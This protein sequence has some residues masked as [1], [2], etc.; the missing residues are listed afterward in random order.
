VHPAD[1]FYTPVRALACRGVISGYSDGSFRPFTMTTRAQVVK[2]LVLGFGLPISVPPGG[3][4]TFADVPPGEVFFAYIET[5]AAHA[6]ISGYTCGGPNEP[7]DDRQR[8]YFRPYGNVTRGQLTKV[9]ALAAGW[10]LLDPPT[11][12][13]ADVAR[14]TPFYTM[15]ETAAAHGI[16]SGYTCGG[17]GEP[18]DPGQRPYFRQGNN[19]TRGQIAKIVYLAVGSGSL[20]H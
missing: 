1:Y 9:T 20:R 10:T 2:I 17:V 18:C 5:A 7:C 12:T 6:L 11:G 3:D 8:P 4:Y 14:G 13:F 15:V 16:I 19:A